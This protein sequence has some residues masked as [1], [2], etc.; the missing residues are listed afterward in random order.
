MCHS[1]ETGGAR[2][3]GQTV[4]RLV[5][6]ESRHQAGWTRCLQVEGP[7]P[8]LD[9]RLQLQGVHFETDR[10]EMNSVPQ[11]AGSHPLPAPPP[12]PRGG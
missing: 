1:L 7:A 3:L 9:F 5:W 4:P 11:S 2:H 8:S 10:C 6:L 12:G